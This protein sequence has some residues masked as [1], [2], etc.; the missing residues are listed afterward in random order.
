MSNEKNIVVGFLAKALEHNSED[1]RC[2]AVRALRG[3]GDHRVDDRVNA[4][5]CKALSD[6]SYGVRSTAAAALGEAG[7]ERTI[8]ILTAKL[9]DTSKDVR[10]AVVDALGHIGL[11]RILEKKTP[12]KVVEPLIMAV[13]DR[14]RDVREFAVLSSSAIGD[15]RTVE[16]LIERLINDRVAFVRSSAGFALFMMAYYG[17]VDGRMIV[18]PLI[19]TIKDMNPSERVHTELMETI[20]IFAISIY[21]T[22]SEFECL[23][24]YLCEALDMLKAMD[25]RKHKAVIAYLGRLLE[26]SWMAKDE[27]I[28]VK[29]RIAKLRDCL[30]SAKA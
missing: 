21:V 30:N 2:D 18:E 7:D 20:E 8:E 24:E 9:K 26:E 11:R 25:A 13:G 22:D 19:E 6:S 1:V 23:F 17:R 14:N 28:S 15:K 5:L 10:Y 12:G 16:P 4:L 3:I 27:R 29:E